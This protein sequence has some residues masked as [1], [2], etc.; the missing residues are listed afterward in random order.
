MKSGKRNSSAGTSLI[1]FAVLGFITGS[2]IKSMKLGSRIE[3]LMKPH[4][5][6]Q[7]KERASQERTRYFMLKAKNPQF[8][9]L[10]AGY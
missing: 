8:T 2:E 6:Q 4:K 1:A 9:L 7:Q 10:L 3:Q 5:M